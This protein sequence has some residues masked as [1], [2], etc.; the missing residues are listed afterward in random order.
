MSDCTLTKSEAFSVAELIDGCLF[1]AIRN[2]T[3]WD[4]MQALKNII[5]AYDKM[6]KASGYVGLTEPDPKEDA[7]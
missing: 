2:D 4:S 1:G 3:E 5:Y 6:C 7:E